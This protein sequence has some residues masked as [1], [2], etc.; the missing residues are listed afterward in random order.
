MQVVEF[1]A[2]IRSERET[3][4]LIWNVSKNN[5][6]NLLDLFSSLCNTR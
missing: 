4:L 5:G 1:G 6:L 3:R 2:L